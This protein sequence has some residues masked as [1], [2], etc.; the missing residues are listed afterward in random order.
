MATKV[1]AYHGVAVNSATSALHVACLALG[2]GDGD[3]LWTSTNTFVA[4]ANCARYCGADVDFVDIDEDTGLMCMKDWLANSRRLESAGNFRKLLFRSTQQASCN[5]AM[6]S[7]LAKRY[8]FA[9][10][11]DASHAIGGQYQ[12]EP[13]GNCRH[14]DITVFSFHPVKII[15]AG[16]GGVAT[17]NSDYLAQCMADLRSHGITKDET[18][19]QL[20]CHGPWSYEQQMLGF[21]YRM[22]DIQAALGLS[23]LERLEDIVAERN[24]QLKYY[25][26]LLDGM[27]IELLK[28]PEGV[29]SSVHLAVIKLKEVSAAKHQKIFKQLREKKIE[30]NYHSPV[31][32]QPYYRNLGFRGTSCRS[33]RKICHEYSSIPRFD[34]RRTK[35]S[36]RN[37][38]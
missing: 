14:S 5:M 15:T 21:N 16:E 20:P 17:T 8:G 11:E 25:E 34:R 37:F 27:E 3:R 7:A 36:C 9:V 23:Q 35:T 30:Y 31:H 24:H 18:R 19:F 4:S 26:K 33:I 32:L 13:V 2:L 38:T 6:I 12:N 10:I 22:T 28:I 1:E 29:L